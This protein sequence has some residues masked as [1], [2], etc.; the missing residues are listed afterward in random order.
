M[1]LCCAEEKSPEVRF[2]SQIYALVLQSYVSASVDCFGE[3]FLGGAVLRYIT[4][5]ISSK[6]VT[7]IPVAETEIPAK[8]PRSRLFGRLPRSKKRSWP[9]GIVWR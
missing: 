5:P 9:C 6:C 4:S 1:S 2:S 3:E 7:V 8:P